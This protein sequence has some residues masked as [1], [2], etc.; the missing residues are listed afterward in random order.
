MTGLNWLK[1]RSLTKS[2]HCV[3]VCVFLWCMC[4]CAHACVYLVYVCL[5][6]SL[7]CVFVCV[8]VLLLFLGTHQQRNAVVLISFPPCPDCLHSPVS[9]ASSPAPHLRFGRLRTAP[10]WAHPL[11]HRAPVFPPTRALGTRLRHTGPP[12]PST[13][14]QT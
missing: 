13:D 6:V 11:H 10:D 5:C 8:C 4:V 7:V 1:V 14:G 3:C 2:R 12:L 9:P